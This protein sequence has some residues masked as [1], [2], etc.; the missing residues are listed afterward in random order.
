MFF[1]LVNEKEASEKSYTPTSNLSEA[2]QQLLENF[3]PHVRESCG[4]FATQ[5]FAR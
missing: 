4:H 5:Q 2:E 1:C 3:R